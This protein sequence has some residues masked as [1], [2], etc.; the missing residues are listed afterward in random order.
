MKKVGVLMVML[1]LTAAAAVPAQDFATKRLEKS[2]R[3]GE[4]VKVKQ[5]KRDVECFV[6]F[7]EVKDKATA[8][9]VIF[10]I[11]AMSDWV[12]GV[13]DQLAEAGHIA[14][15]PDLLSGMGAKGGGSKDFGSQEVNKAVSSL[16]ADQVNADL[17]AVGDY[18]VKLPACNGKLTV[19]GFCWGGGKSFHFATEPQRSQSGLC[20]L[21]QLPANQ[22]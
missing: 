2:P 17:N 9:I 15:V 1:I 11:F 21:R 22:G 7:P 5:G 13:A 16:K 12:R 4:W 6:V 14:I 10:D 18:V 19:S 20:L 3:H 8:V